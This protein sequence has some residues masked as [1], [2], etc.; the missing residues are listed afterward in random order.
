M[1]QDQLCHIARSKAEGECPDDGEVCESCCEHDEL[2]C[3]HC[4]DCGADRT[5]DMM[6]AAYDRAKDA[7]KYGDT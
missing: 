1:S 6:A 4:L 7:R 2:D 5:E 3:G